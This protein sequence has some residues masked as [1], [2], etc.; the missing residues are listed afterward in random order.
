[1]NTNALSYCPNNEDVV[2]LVREANSK[3]ESEDYTHFQ[4]ITIDML[5]LISLAKNVDK[6]DQWEDILL[7]LLID[8]NED[9]SLSALKAYCLSNE[10]AGIY[11][12]ELI[13]FCQ[14][15]TYKAAI[16]NH[17]IDESATWFKAEHRKVLLK[18]IILLL[19]LK[20]RK[21][22]G[23]INKT[24]E[25]ARRKAVSNFISTITSDD[26]NLFWECLLSPYRISIN[27]VIENRICYS[28][29]K[30]LYGLMQSL[31]NI[32]EAFGI[33]ISPYSIQL[34]NLILTLIADLNNAINLCEATADVLYLAKEYKNL[35]VVCLKRMHQLIQSHMENSADVM[36]I[37][38]RL[39]GIFEKHFTDECIMKTQA[40]SCLVQVVSLWCAN[41]KNSYII[42]THPNICKAVAFMLE[43][44]QKEEILMPI[45]NNLI[46]LAKD[47]TQIVEV[48]RKNDAPIEKALLTV[49]HRYKKKYA[50]N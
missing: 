45:M 32:I 9:I 12:N 3:M 40:T 33:K 50:T 5:T 16:T 39:Y 36:P 1:M 23:K 49:G 15:S 46:Q 37:N 38:E 44:C 6:I 13:E 22:K 21:K 2:K 11:T 20:I 17:Y 48:I 24:S 34:S 41:P 26:M 31:K 10:V 29:C 27:K 35:R 7:C 30:N 47:N 14:D 43:N 25:I 4:N 18:M 28:S 42:I 19:L 8:K